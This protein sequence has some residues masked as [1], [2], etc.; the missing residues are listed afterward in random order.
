LAGDFQMTTITTPDGFEAVLLDGGDHS[1]QVICDKLNDTHFGGTLP[2]ISVFAV[3]SISHPTV[4]VLH[5]ITL[6]TQEFPDLRGIQTPWV[7]LIQEAYCKLPFAVQLLLH[8]MT[9]VLYPDENHTEQ[10]W[11]ALR[12]KWLIDLPLVLGVGLHEDE[13]PTGLIKELLDSIF[14]C[15]R[16]GL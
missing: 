1:L 8:E 12:A 4:Q 14:A 11:T 7:I 3:R 15:R 13:S 5:A 2:A 16:L 6:K 9:H 10:F